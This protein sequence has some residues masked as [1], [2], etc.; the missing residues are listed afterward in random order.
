V[1][2]FGLHHYVLCNVDTNCL[3]TVNGSI[4]IMQLFLQKV[5]LRH[6]SSLHAACERLKMAAGV[7]DVKQLFKKN[8]K[9]GT[10]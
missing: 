9:I 2:V 8:Q 3:C 4:D 5:I 1:I 10:V 7:T 6:K